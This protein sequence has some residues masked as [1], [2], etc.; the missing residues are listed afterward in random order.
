MSWRPPSSSTNTAPALRVTLRLEEDVQAYLVADSYEDERRLRLW[1]A[2]SD[3][4]ARLVA[5]L[6]QLIDEERAA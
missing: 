4:V 6:A 1:L 3:V 2:R 5:L